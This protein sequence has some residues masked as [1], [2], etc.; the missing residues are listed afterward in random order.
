APAAP[1]DAHEHYRRGQEAL[2]AH[3]FERARAEYEAAWLDKEHLDAH[4]R[5][6]VRLGMA[7]VN[8]NRFEGRKVGMEIERLWPGDPDLERFK[9]EFAE[10]EPP[11]KGRPRPRW[12]K[13]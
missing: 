13:P 7:V 1:V 8:H 3:D 6:F 10:E 11:M 5:H 12:R 2:F 9:R 4:D